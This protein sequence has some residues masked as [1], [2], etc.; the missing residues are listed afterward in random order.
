MP[1]Y[2]SVRQH[3][4]RGNDYLIKELSNDDSFAAVQSRRRACVELWLG[5][6]MVQ[7]QWHLDVYTQLKLKKKTLCVCVCVCVCVWRHFLTDPIVI[8]LFKENAA[9]WQCPPFFI[10]II[11]CLNP[12]ENCLK[13]GVFQIN[14]LD[15]NMRTVQWLSDA[16]LNQDTHTH[17]HTHTS[18]ST[19]K[20]SSDIRQHGTALY[21]QKIHSCFTK[22]STYTANNQ[23]PAVHKEKSRT[24]YKN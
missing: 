7:L 5:S 16:R 10:I 11:F 2:L 14:S 24:V 20:W 1:L 8:K 19:S 21:G 22:H 17:T 18:Y 3:W 4:R 6:H 15:C 12:K 23:S 13:N 9:G